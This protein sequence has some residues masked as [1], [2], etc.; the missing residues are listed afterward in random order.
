MSYIDKALAD[1]S[2]V[3]KKPVDILADEDLTDEQ[4]LGVL[5][6]WECDARQILMADEEN[7]V[8][9]SPS[10]LHRVLEC[11]EKLRKPDD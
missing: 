2:S 3:Y 1:P 7:M 5:R 11:I 6:Q 10:M 4:K 9:D 8:G